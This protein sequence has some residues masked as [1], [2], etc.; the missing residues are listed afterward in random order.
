MFLI[1]LKFF[2]LKIINNYKYIYV[3]VN[4]NIKKEFFL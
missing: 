4:Y 2:Y 3:I 1:L